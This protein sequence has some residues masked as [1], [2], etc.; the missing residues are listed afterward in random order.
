MENI[1]FVPCVCF[2]KRG[3]AKTNPDKVRLSTHK[4]YSFIIFIIVYCQVQLTKEELAEIIN[5]AKEE[6]ELVSYYLY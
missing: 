1:N 4:R 3:V 5:K 2:V 6:I